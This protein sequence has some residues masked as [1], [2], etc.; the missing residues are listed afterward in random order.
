MSTSEGVSRM[1]DP[2]TVRAEQIRETTGVS[3]ETACIR[4]ERERDEPEHI[5]TVRTGT[6]AVCYALVRDDIACM[7]T[8]QRAIELQRE[9]VPYVARP[10]GE[11]RCE[12]DFAHFYH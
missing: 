7:L 9:G 12:A 10:A 1:S 5:E 2:T 8:T 3:W 6:S 11:M 4:A